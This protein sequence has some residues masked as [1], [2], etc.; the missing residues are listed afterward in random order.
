MR[1]SERVRGKL[2]GGGELVFWRGGELGRNRD[3]LVFRR[4][5]FHYGVEAVYVVSRV[6]DHPDGT[7]WLDQAVSA[8]HSAVFVAYFVM[9]FIVTG[10]QV[11]YCVLVVIRF[12]PI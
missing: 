8:F 10:N 7:V 5:F 3:G 4:D 12:W 1:V 11:V 6:L 2:G 9:A